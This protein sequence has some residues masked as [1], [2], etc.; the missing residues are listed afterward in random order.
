MELDSVFN[1]FFINVV[2]NELIAFCQKDLFM[3]SNEGSF[4]IPP[5]LQYSLLNLTD[6][7]WDILPLSKE[8]IVIGFGHNYL[9]KYNLKENKIICERRGEHNCLL[10]SMSLYQTSDNHILVLA[11]TI[12]NKIVIWDFLDGITYDIITG[13][14]GVLFKVNWS[15]NG[16]FLVSASDDRTIRLWKHSSLKE[17]SNQNP[18]ISGEKISS[19]TIKNDGK[20]ENVFSSFG[21]TA[22]LWDCRIS[23]QYVISSS[24]DC[25]CRV[26]DIN[27]KNLTVLSGHNGKHI[28]SIDIFKNIIVTGGNDSSVKIWNLNEQLAQISNN[29]EEKETEII[30]S[31][32]SISSYSPSSCIKWIIPSI[33][34]NIF[35]NKTDT[36]CIRGIIFTNDGKFCYLSSYWG[37]I[38]K[39][40]MS[41]GKFQELVKPKSDTKFG[42]YNLLSLSL[43]E[44]LLITGDAN[45]NLY[46]IKCKEE[47]ETTQIP[48]I[49]NVSKV[50]IMRVIFDNNN[51]YEDGKYRIYLC[52]AN[53]IISS[54]L[55]EERKEKDGK[56]DI[57]LISEYIL[58]DKT[59]GTTVTVDV[60]NELL[61][62]GDALGEIHIYKLIEY[63][64]KK[65]E[66]EN[67][68]NL[69]LK[70]IKKVHKFNISKIIIT[71]NNNNILYSIGNN[72]KINTYI[73]KYNK[74]KEIEKD[75]N[76]IE[77]RLI[78]SVKAGPVTSISDIYW[79]SNNEIIIYGF[80]ESELFIY[81][82]TNQYIIFRIESGG[83][84]RPYDIWCDK[85]HPIRGFSIA[86]AGI[87]SSSKLISYSTVYKGIRKEKERGKDDDKEGEKEE[88]IDVVD[89]ESSLKLSKCAVNLNFHGLEIDSIDILT[90][91]DGLI[92]L[93]NNEIY[94]I[95]GGEDTTCKILKY[96]KLD[97]SISLIETLEKHISSIQTITHCNYP[98]RNEPLLFTCGG[99]RLI[100]IWKFHYLSNEKDEERDEEKNR[101]N[102]YSTKDPII[103]E[104]I[105]TYPKEGTWA[106]LQQDQRIL[107][108]KSIPLPN[109]Y[110]LLLYL[111]ITGNSEGEITIYGF[112]ERYNVLE[113]MYYSDEIN[114][115]ILSLDIESIIDYS[116][117]SEEYV[118]VSG[119]TDGVI[120]IWNIT[121]I[122][123]EYIEK[124]YKRTNF[125]V[126]PNEIYNIKPSKMTS[127]LEVKGINKMGVN[128]LTLIKNPNN[129]K[130]LIISTV[131]DDQS[132]SVGYFLV[133]NKKEIKWYGC[134]ERIDCITTSSLKSIDSCHELVFIS[135]YDQKSILMKLNFD[136]ADDIVDKYEVKEVYIDECKY[137]KEL[138]RY[139][140]ISSVIECV[141]MCR[142]EDNSLLLLTGGSGLSINKCE[143]V[144]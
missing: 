128:D 57:I 117:E 119:R 14:E 66:K 22:R 115:P 1:H 46:I 69:P 71:P 83:W 6:L 62:V 19:L 48:L 87:K 39:L 81:D 108:S 37:Y 74:N 114:R 101:D 41:T 138:M 72:G 86:F 111:L 142:F 76:N 70:T 59:F 58:P 141:K 132:L 106:K 109:K 60:K 2:E 133:N 35:N 4:K 9:Q 103:I 91:K 12:F 80:H 18:F 135:G 67:K 50:R 49:F 122:M 15:R 98:G 127:I 45:G 94:I 136:I 36:E 21:H 85:D 61:F 104:N 28:W 11:G 65:E 123:N 75:S 23:D 79:T 131:G 82:V 54:Y 17:I 118:L 93:N 51:I 32:S 43:N 121:E 78:N 30:S 110:N 137:C 97:N 84:R 134:I 130:C 53:G 89:D 112:D 95:T 44:E 33:Q 34:N 77:F 24:E 129:N 96:N 140:S 16:Y 107:S 124:S 25:T 144:E 13:H 90:N 5:K 10:Y 73:Y 56:I 68:K 139:I 126:N 99:R 100:N 3:Y 40:D 27:G 7:I 26:W 92:H 52:F 143:Y 120:N 102:N 38:W 31:F 29:K 47:D 105:S 8:E 88:E 55:L 64:N 125:V 20:Y 42:L 63:N 116:L 113:S